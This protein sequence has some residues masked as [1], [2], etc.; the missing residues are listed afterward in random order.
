MVHISR[1]LAEWDWN[2]F[3]L[4]IEEYIYIYIDYCTSQSQCISISNQWKFII[5]IKS[6]INECY[7]L[8]KRFPLPDTFTF[9]FNKHFKIYLNWGLG[10]AMVFHTQQFKK[11][12]KNTNSKIFRQLI[13]VVWTSFQIIRG[14]QR[15]GSTFSSQRSVFRSE[16]TILNGCSPISRFLISF[17]IFFGAWHKTQGTYNLIMYTKTCI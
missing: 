11:R 17:F 2:R 6:W 5:A 4:M 1:K 16:W 9:Y 13:L 15:T 7:G 8:F 3:V 12:F 14:E 10:T